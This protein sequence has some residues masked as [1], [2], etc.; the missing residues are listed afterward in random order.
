MAS[1]Y[2]NRDKSGNK[3]SLR[4]AFIENS[5]SGADP[6]NPLPSWAQEKVP[7]AWK[8]KTAGSHMPQLASTLYQKLLSDS[9]CFVSGWSLDLGSGLC[10]PKL[11]PWDCRFWKKTKLPFPK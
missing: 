10:L 9:L 8:G 11:S 2:L 7:P 6:L 3:L 4:T 5:Y 1:K